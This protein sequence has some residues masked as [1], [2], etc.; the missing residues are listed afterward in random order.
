MDANRSGA[1]DY[2]EFIAAT[3]AAEQYTREDV[4]WNAFGVFDR[5][6]SGSISRKEMEEARRGQ[7]FSQELGTTWH[8]KVRILTSFSS[9]GARQ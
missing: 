8:R 2:C 7:A 6:R 4:C 3:L 9:E 1:V 5:D